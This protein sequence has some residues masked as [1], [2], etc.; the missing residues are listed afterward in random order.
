VLLVAKYLFSKKEH[1]FLINTK[2]KWIKMNENTY[3][4][5]NYEYMRAFTDCTDV[6]GIGE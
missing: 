3:D 1:V 4:P 6:W 5:S 2:F